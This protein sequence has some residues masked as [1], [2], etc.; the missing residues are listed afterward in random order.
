M[1]LFTIKFQHIGPKDTKGGIEGYVLADTEQNVMKGI[2]KL[3]NCGLWGDLLKKTEDEN[4]SH[5]KK[6]HEDI[7]VYRGEIDHPD[8]DYGDA[9]YGITFYGWDEGKE[10]S[11]Q[12]AQLLV[13]LGIA[14]NWFSNTNLHPPHWTDL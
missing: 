8:N 6:Y 2:D 5:A 13:R 1:K 9:Y 14:Q 11:L 4:L 10:I 3:Y 12:E 7:L